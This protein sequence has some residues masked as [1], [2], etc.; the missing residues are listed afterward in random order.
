MRKPLDTPILIF[1]WI[2][3]FEKHTRVVDE[4]KKKAV[5]ALP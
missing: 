4:L 1:Q 3:Y 5:N 2:K